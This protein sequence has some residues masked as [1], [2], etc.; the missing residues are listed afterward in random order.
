MQTHVP[1]LKQMTKEDSYKNY[2]Y[3]F[4]M[5][6]HEAEFAWSTGNIFLLANTILV[7]F[8]GSNFLSPQKENLWL[9]L[10]TSVLG[11]LISIFWY[12]TFKR[13]IRRHA[14]WTARARDYEEDKKIFNIFSG[15]TKILADGGIVVA[16]GEK[17]DLKTWGFVHLPI[18]KSLQF[19]IF[20][21]ILFYLIVLVMGIKWV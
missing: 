6:M 15:D 21:F 19:V 12:F 18:H 16:D 10:S 14:Y 4:K 13:I 20:L 9:V 3:I 17:F 8:V 5:A 11:I 7:A 2:E 1:H